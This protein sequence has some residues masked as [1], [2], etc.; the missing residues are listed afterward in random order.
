M[1]KFL[2]WLSRG[3]E[4]DWYNV[5]DAHVWEQKKQKDMDMERLKKWQ[6]EAF[7]WGDSQE[8]ASAYEK[9]GKLKGPNHDNG[10][11]DINVEGGEYIVKKDSVNQN[12]LDV[13][14]YINSYGDIPSSDARERSK[15]NA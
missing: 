13:L 11:I 10:G 7:T 2:N 14:E 6:D 12:T 9:G 4:K 8:T 3:G 5:G 15:K 1:G